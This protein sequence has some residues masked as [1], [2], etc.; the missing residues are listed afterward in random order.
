MQLSAC[1][2]DE[3]LCCQAEVIAVDI[4][5]LQRTGLADRDC[6]EA[7]SFKSACPWA[8]F[9][10]RKGI[11]ALES[12]SGLPL[13]HRPVRHSVG[14]CVV[15][16]P[17]RL[18]FFADSDGWVYALDSVTGNEKWKSGMMNDAPEDPPG[19]DGDDARF[20]GTAARP[21]GIATDGQMVYQSV[22]DQCR[23][24]AFDILQQK[25]R[26]IF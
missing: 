24:V 19:F 2:E 16:E 22:F 11:S 15:W 26:S 18:V 17:K 25:S 8:D 9:T 21:T 12:D 20:E 6:G 3:W 5:N 7:A 14:R 10:T 23:V 13:W 1:C 4:L